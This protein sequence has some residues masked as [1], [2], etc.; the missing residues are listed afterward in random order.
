M[1]VLT[2]GTDRVCLV[3]PEHMLTPQ[4]TSS[5]RPAARDYPPGCGSCVMGGLFKAVG[6]PW[7][8]R[9]V[10]DSRGNGA[11]ENT[12]SM[13]TSKYSAIFSAKYRLGLYSPRSR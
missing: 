9:A 4:I 1:A 3:Y 2:H 13:G 7:R 10:Q 5:Q 12:I 6:I 8:R 11:V